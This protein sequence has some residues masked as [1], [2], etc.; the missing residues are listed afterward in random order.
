MEASMGWICRKVWLLVACTGIALHSAD[1][2]KAEVASPKP[3]V[4]AAVA[5]FDNIDSAGEDPAR[6]AEHAARVAGFADLLRN[7]LSDDAKYKIVS[8]RC[9]VSPCSAKSMPGDDLLEAARQA[10]ARILVY[11]GIHKMSTLIQWAV[12]QA[13]DVQ[14]GKLL[15]DRR[16]TFRGDTDEAFRRAAEFIAPYIETAGTAPSP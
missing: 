9:A 5:D 2:L 10:G 12:V 3:A 14:T 13:V 6:T 15:L 11:G 8:L 1:G 4:T 7:R 16:I